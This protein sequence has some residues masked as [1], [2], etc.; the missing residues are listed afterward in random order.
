MGLMPGLTQN[1]SEFRVRV[2]SKRVGLSNR[3]AGKYDHVKD[4]HMTRVKDQ[5]ECGSCWAFTATSVLE[6]T[7]AA[8]TGKKP[9]RISEQQLVDCTLEGTKDKQGNFYHNYGCN[10]GWMEEAWDY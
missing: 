8:K 10:G 1:H 3:H 7:L 6:G 4:R 2:N 5:G 9:R